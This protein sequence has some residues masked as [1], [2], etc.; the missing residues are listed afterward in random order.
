[1][2][3]NRSILRHIYLVPDFPDA[4]VNG[5]H[6][7]VVL[8]EVIR[9]RGIFILSTSFILSV[10]RVADPPLCTELV[11]YPLDVILAAGQNATLALDPLLKIQFISIL[12]MLYLQLSLQTSPLLT[13]WVVMLKPDKN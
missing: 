9:D 3:L 11:Q 4:M 6:L 2:V 8:A 5:S 1:M 10:Y 7:P 13:K 12:Q